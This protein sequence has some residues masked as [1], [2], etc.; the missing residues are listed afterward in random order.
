[1]VVH[2]RREIPY[3]CEKD[4]QQSFKSILS[5]HAITL[6]DDYPMANFLRKYSTQIRTLLF[7]YECIDCIV[8]KKSAPK[9][10]EHR[11]STHVNFNSQGGFLCHS[12]LAKIKEIVRVRGDVDTRERWEMR[13]FLYSSDTRGKIHSWWRNRY[14]KTVTN[15]QE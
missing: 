3:S 13:I 10:D 7:P 5:I 14:Y 2:N 4:V 6:W 9:K 1:M 15:L 8:L 12:E 11:T